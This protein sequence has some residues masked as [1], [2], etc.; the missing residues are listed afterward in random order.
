MPVTSVDEKLSIHS[1]SLASLK[2]EIDLIEQETGANVFHVAYGFLE[3]YLNPDFYLRSP[4][5]FVSN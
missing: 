3:E 5:L 1:R 2:L 4:I